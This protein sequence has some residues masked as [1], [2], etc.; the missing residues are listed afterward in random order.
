MT[1]SDTVSALEVHIREQPV[2][3]QPSLSILGLDISSTG[4]PHHS[5][6]ARRAAASAKWFALVREAGV[7]R[8]SIATINRLH[9]A[10]YVPSLAYGLSA[11]PMSTSLLQHLSRSSSSHLQRYYKRPPG[12]D[13][14]DWITSARSRI[15]QDRLSGVLQTPIQYIASDLQAMHSLSESSRGT[16]L[17]DVLQWRNAAWLSSVDRNYRPQQRKGGDNLEMTLI[18]DDLQRLTFHRL[19]IA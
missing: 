14:G 6:L 19:H 5:I 15:R 10:L 2:R 11:L 18:K 7:H 13:I 8:L 17:Q 4:N 12:M 3:K 16:Q 1:A 9:N